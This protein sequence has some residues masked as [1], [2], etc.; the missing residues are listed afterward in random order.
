MMWIRSASRSASSMWWVVS[1]TVT[2]SPRS[3]SS[4][5]HVV[6]RPAGSI[7][8]VGSS[9]KTS[10]GR[11]DDRHGELESLLLAPGEP[12]VRRAAAVAQP[13]P[14]TELVDVEGVGVQLG[15]VAEHLR[16]ACAGPRPPSC[17]IT[18]MRGAG[19]G[20]RAAGPG[21][22]PGRSRTGT[23]IPSQVS[24]VVVLPAPFG[25]DGR[26][27]ASIDSQV[28]P[29]D[30]HL[31][32]VRI[33]SPDLHRRRGGGVGHPG[34]LRRG[35]QSLD[36]G[37]LAEMLQRVAD[38]TD[39]PPAV[40]GGSQLRSTTRS[41]H[42]HPSAPGTP[43]SRAPPRG[44]P[45]SR[46][47]PGAPTR[48]ARAVPVA[49]VPVVQGQLEALTPLAQTCSVP[50]RPATWSSSI[51]RVPQQP[52]DRVAPLQP[53]HRAASGPCPGRARRARRR[54]ARGCV[55]SGR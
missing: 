16:R 54:T 21:R 23:A 38:D 30:G 10:S 19:P 53:S 27:R 3:S 51:R 20:A 36:V 48:P 49:V 1:T 2:P 12:A 8:A 44:S 28:E 5:A 40:T 43:T 42:R 24:S 52:D 46:R 41:S 50:A 55:G 45:S 6:R 7:P 13:H 31:V 22:G 37:R 26:D 14:V 25:Q 35:R 11:P 9:T 33:T 4:R 15:D 39:Q 18:P 34:S 47:R 32:A 29:V 17:S